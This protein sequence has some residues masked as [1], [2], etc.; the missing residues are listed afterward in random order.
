MRITLEIGGKDRL[1]YYLWVAGSAL[2]V[3]FLAL[4]TY[5]MLR[6]TFFPIIRWD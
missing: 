2:F 3:I 1:P 5:W 6:V 4:L